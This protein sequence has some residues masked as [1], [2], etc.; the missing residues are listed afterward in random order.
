LSS[1]RSSTSTFSAASLASSRSSGCNSGR[2]THSEEQQPPLP[3]TALAA[4]HG[5]SASTDEQYPETSNT[6]SRSATGFKGKKMAQQALQAAVG[7][8]TLA[9]RRFLKHHSKGP[10]PGP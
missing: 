4:H 10:T 8:R 9:Q 2:S 3:P 1:S 6:G 7:G 5:G